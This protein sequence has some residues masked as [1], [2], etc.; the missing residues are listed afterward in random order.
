MEPSVS[1]GEALSYGTLEHGQPSVPKVQEAKGTRLVHT[2]T[3]LEEGRKH[4]AAFLNGS[5]IP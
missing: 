1:L 4:V 3:K 5:M 2:A